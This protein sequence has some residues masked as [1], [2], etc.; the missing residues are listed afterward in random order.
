MFT[1]IDV[2]FLSLAGALFAFGVPIAA[3]VPATFAVI[4]PGARWRARRREG[5]NPVARYV[6]AE[7]AD[8][9][10][11]VVR[12]ARLRGV[13]DG[14]ASVAAS[15][16]VLLDVATVLVGR[17]PR[18]GSTARFVEDRV[19]QLGRMADGLDEER[20]AWLAAV[21]EVEA[22]SPSP[23]AEAP[24]DAEDGRL[25]TVLLVVLVPFFLTWD[26]ARGTVR[27]IV[28][29]AVG[30]RLRIRMAGRL[31]LRAGR[32]LHDRLG[33]VVRRWA[34]LRARL[35]G[36]SREARRRFVAVRLRYR[37]AWLRG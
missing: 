36:A 18:R 21:T 25:V 24:R 37:R 22:L 10:R 33:L 31:L 4:M 9:H 6:P 1:W 19:A 5:T 32:V 30:C 8:A 20:A 14:A 34:H 28:A 2:F 15:D 16:R 11:R 13:T 12:A 26:L 29:L 3:V 27:V 7:V 23:P 35:G 17:P